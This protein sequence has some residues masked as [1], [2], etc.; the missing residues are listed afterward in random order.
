[1]MLLMGFLIVAFALWGVQGY[2]S[3]SANSELAS[4]NGEEISLG[5]YNDRLN[6]QRQSMLNRFGDSIDS[7]YF[8]STMFKRN[9]LESMINS[10]LLRQ[11]AANT[12]FVVTDAE[13]KSVIQEAPSFKNE[14]GEFDKNLYAAF[15]TQTNQSAAYL[16]QQIKQGLFDT[17]VNDTIETTAFITVK[18]RQKLASL[19]NQ[20]RNFDYVLIKPN[21]FIEQV[22]LEPSETEQHY[23]ENQGSYMTPEKVS[24]DY[25]RINADNIAKEI[26][27]GDQEA[28]QYFEDNK[29]AY[30]GSEQRQASHILINDAPDALEKI[31]ELK[32]QL[33][34]GAIFAELA[35]ENSQDPGSKDSGGDLGWVKSGDMVTEF[36]DELF[37]MDKGSISEPIKTEFGYHLIYLKDIKP[38]QEP[39]FEAV[40]QDIVQA[41]QAQQAEVL[42]LDKVS[43]LSSLVLDAEDNLDA[44]ADQSGIELQTTELFDRNSGQGIAENPAVREVAFS[45]IVKDELQNSDAINLSDTDIVFIHLHQVKEAELKPLA[46]VKQ[47]IEDTLKNNKAAELA[48]QQA[49]T[50]AEQINQQGKTLAE[51]AEAKQLPIVNAKQIKRTGSSHPYNL[52]KNVFSMDK[53]GREKTITAVQ[54]SDGNEL[55]VVTLTAVQDGI[56]DDQT[57]LTAESDQLLRNLKANEQ[58]LLIKALRAASTI[59]VN[60]ELLEK[61]QF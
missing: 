12:G 28:L 36:N 44:V 10:K 58:Q 17:A 26:E 32:N 41:L 11:M 48:Q 20:T 54:N 14:Q 18:E 35:K 1:M 30:Q 9:L 25:I 45:T 55:A 51:L 19:N 7:S 6:Q 29:Q 13:I 61:G 47:S 60:Q 42:F 2:F 56:V 21:N 59:R 24:I 16:Q 23:K 33:N 3:Q 5:E 8:E 39:I 37:E 46:E 53:P 27:I 57:D 4:V 50:M 15:L 22:K 49:D 43:E 38:P 40:K 34:N 52:V 31:T